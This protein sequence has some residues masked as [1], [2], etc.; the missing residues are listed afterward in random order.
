[1]LDVSEAK[2]W[3]VSLQRWRQ[4]GSNKESNTT[5]AYKKCPT[6][7]LRSD[8]LHPVFRFYNDSESYSKPRANKK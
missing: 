7:W 1:M 6:E 3:H 2:Q 5:R 8:K 4:K